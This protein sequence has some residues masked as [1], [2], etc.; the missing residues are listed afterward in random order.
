MLTTFKIAS[1]LILGHSLL[2][3]A[4]I[5]K[6]DT[7]S[8]AYAEQAVEAQQNGETAH[9]IEL[10]E[11]AV[12]GGIV[13][14]DLFYNLGNAYF[15]TNDIGHAMAS[16]LAA[17]RFSPRNPD[18]KANLKFVHTQIQENLKYSEPPSTLN[19]LAFWVDDMTSK[20]AFKL[21]ALLSLISGL[22]II[23]GVV[24][25]N[26]STKKIGVFSVVLPIL[27][28]L[29]FYI[30]DQ[31]TSDNLTWGAVT[32]AEAGVHS[33]I[34]NK[35]KVLFNLKAGAPIKMIGKVAGWYQIKLSD[36]K[37]GWIEE[38]DAKV[39]VPF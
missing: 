12:A 13:N 3:N 8:Q 33:D 24:F 23:A 10:Y 37:K 14:G 30:V 32:A 15:R 16:F 11:K 1:V 9:A 29:N 4:V 36:G 2:F 35:S 17:K 38:S 26:S 31:N 27:A 39:Y 22:I 7:A 19:T 18:I 6:A 34:N 25:S 5:A 21:L 20:E 28:A